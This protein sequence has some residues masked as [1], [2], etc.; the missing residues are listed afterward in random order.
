[1]KLET[2]HEDERHDPMMDLA[3]ASLVIV[4]GHLEKL[5]YTVKG[6]S[7]WFREYPGSDV[8]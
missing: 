5:G 8:S 4:K 6:P 7:N 1:M 2:L 3:R